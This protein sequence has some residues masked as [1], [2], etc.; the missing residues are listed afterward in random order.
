MRVA[1]FF[2]RIKLLA[3]ALILLTIFGCTSTLKNQTPTPRQSPT[4]QK[5]QRP[6]LKVTT[7]TKGSTSIH[8]ALGNPSGAIAS[9]ANPDNYLLIKP[10][11]ALSYNRSKGIANWASW[12]LNKSWLGTTDRQDN[13]RPDEALPKGWQQVTSS[14]YSGSG[15]DRGH[16]VPSADRTKSDEDNS[17]TFL[18]T[19]MLP[20]TPDNNRRTWEGLESYCR[21]LVKQGKELYIIAGPY[22]RQKQLLKGKVVIPQTTWKVVFVLDRPGTGVSGVTQ[23]TRAIAV[24][25]PNKQGINPDWRTYRV[26]VKKIEG[27]TGYNFLSNIPTVVQDVIEKKIDTDSDV[28]QQSSPKSAPVLLN[29]RKSTEKTTKKTTTA[30][31][32][33]RDC[34]PD[35]PIRDK[36]EVC[37]KP[38]KK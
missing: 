12:E 32:Q 23:N 26:S 4:L 22:G 10:Q 37:K 21:D 16:L 24:N 8:L 1:Q 29:S 35:S 13:F 30:T 19:N 15:Y 9:V 20:E 11:Y 7:T 17:A 18:M 31:K 28:S 14:D 36:L 27:L 3:A 33:T 34:S 6:T 5:P 25:V 38:V 2:G